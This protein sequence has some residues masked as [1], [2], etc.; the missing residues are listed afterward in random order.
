[1]PAIDRPPQRIAILLLPS[2]SN[3]TLAG[4]LEP[5]RVANRFAR[6]PLFA[7]TIVTEDG[8]P[9]ASSSGLRVAP[10]A[11]MEAAG[12]ADAVYVVASYDAEK[13]ISARIKRWLRARARAGVL[14]GGMETG[15]YVLAAAGVLDGYKATTHWLDL[16]TFAERFPAVAVVP[17]RFV[18]DRDRVTSGGALPTLDLVLD[19]LRRTQ[20]LGLAIAVSSQ[21]IYEPE[22]AGRD[23][24]HM[25]SAGR[26]TWQDPVLG[27]AIRAMEE[28]IEEPLPVEAIA[29]RAGVGP[30]ELLRRFRTKLRTAPKTYYAELRLTLGRRLL[31]HTDRPVGDIAV[32]CGFGSASAFA[33]AFRGRFST[34]P[35][36]FR[37]QP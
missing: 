15:A 5:L 35:T 27:R 18:V 8:R 12:P 36:A 20:G 10:D 13:H 16:D 23:P 2:F 7:W 6:S 37:R 17:D 4:L 3:L 31:E 29:A 32:T 30:R 26:L 22:H 24:Q 11:A 19:Q 33:R 25:V 14:L 21:F 9:A 1:M 34:S 28:N